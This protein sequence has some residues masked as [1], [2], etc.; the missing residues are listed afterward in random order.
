VLAELDGEYQEEIFGPVAVLRKFKTDKEAIKIANE[1]PYGL[2]AS[3]WGEK[4]QITK[5]VGDIEAGMV[6]INSIVFS[7]PRLPFGG[8]KKSGIG[9]ELSK[10]GSREFTNLKTVWI[11]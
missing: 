11:N 1:T 4:T 2:G 6:F 10:Y 3:I 5:L 7:D 9:R 8:V